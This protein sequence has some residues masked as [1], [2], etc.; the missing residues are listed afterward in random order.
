MKKI[1]FLALA[2]ALAS[3]SVQ[4]FSRLPSWM[5]PDRAAP[6][7]G[8]SQGHSQGHTQEQ[9]RP[10]QRQTASVPEPALPFL[11][12]TSLGAVL[13]VKRLSRFGK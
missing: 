5:V 9:N 1:V 3:G 7:Q 11:L 4:A 2:L 8:H 12:L 10:E 6:V 13:A